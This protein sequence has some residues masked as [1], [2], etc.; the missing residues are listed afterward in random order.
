MSRHRPELDNFTPAEIRVLAEHL[1]YT[2]GPEARG[3]LMEA[4][5][6]LY[7][8]LFPSADRAC[9]EKFAATIK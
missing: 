3:T 7:I 8:R 6:T 5:P 1:L 2:M 4:Y 9:L